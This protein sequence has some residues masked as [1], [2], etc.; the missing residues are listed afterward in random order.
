[1]ID[2]TFKAAEQLGVKIPETLD[3]ERRKLADLAEKVRHYAVNADLP[4]AVLNSLAAGR[5]PATDPAVIEVVV[6]RSL[7]E[8]TDGLEWQL[9]IRVQTLADD[10]AD[11][12]LSLFDEPFKRAATTIEQAA[13]QLGDVSLD[14]TATVLARGG[15]AAGTWAAAQNAVSTIDTIVTTRKVLGNLARRLEV[16]PRYRLLAL[17]DVPPDVFLDEQL[18]GTTLG[19]WDIARRGWT[20]SLATPTVLRQRIAAITAEQASREQAAAGAFREGYRRTRGV[21]VA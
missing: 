11:E 18:G 6:R 4:D 17:A 7:S 10:H 1:M 21:G 15:D 13:D 8:I 3:T 9:A 16:D 14:D 12:L 19:P 5:D 20:L 2:Q